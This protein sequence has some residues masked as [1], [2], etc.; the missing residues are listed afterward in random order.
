[1][2][3]YRSPTSARNLHDQHRGGPCPACGGTNTRKDDPLRPRPGILSVILFGWIAILVRTAFSSQ[4]QSCRDCGA[5]RQT[6]S[7]ANLV[8]FVILLFLT[9]C[10]VVAVFSD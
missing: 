8:A 10:L 2:D 5:S 6:R 1:M 9:A 4:T 7:T 3:P